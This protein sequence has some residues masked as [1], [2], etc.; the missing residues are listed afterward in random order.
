MVT[1][2]LPTW[3]WVCINPQQV[4]SPALPVLFKVFKKIRMV[5][6]AGKIT[7]F[8]LKQCNLK[9]NHTS[10]TKQLTE[11]QTGNVTKFEVSMI[12]VQI[13]DFWL[14]QYLVL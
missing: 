11:Q 5:D 10:E 9:G 6:D 8:L 4:N 7:M 1:N 14:L 3:G 12:R 13:M 2:T